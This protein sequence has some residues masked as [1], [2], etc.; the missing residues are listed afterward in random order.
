MNEE[1]IC[2][3]CGEGSCT[4]RFDPAIMAAATAYFKAI[5]SGVRSGDLRNAEKARCRLRE[6]Q[7]D[8]ERPRA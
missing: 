4:C 1:M 3:I 6:V 2:L 8:A 5:R 7:A